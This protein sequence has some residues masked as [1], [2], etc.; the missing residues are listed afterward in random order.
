M[1]ETKSTESIDRYVLFDTTIVATVFADGSL[2][3]SGGC[4]T[5]QLSLR[6]PALR[7]LYRLLEANKGV[8]LLTEHLISQ[9]ER[10][11]KAIEGLKVAKSIL[12]DQEI[13]HYLPDRYSSEEATLLGIRWEDAFLAVCAALKAAEPEGAETRQAELRGIYSVWKCFRDMRRKALDAMDFGGSV[14]YGQAAAYIIDNWGEELREA[15]FK[16]DA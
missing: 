4:G 15:G 3:I 1:S 14:K 8:I 16:R 13:E 12:S 6:P 5:F 2:R 9:Q 11:L 7:D 10:L